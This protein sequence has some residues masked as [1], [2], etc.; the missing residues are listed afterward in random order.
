MPPE[1]DDVRMRELW[2]DFKEGVE[3]QMC[4]CKAEDFY[5][6]YGYEKRGSNSQCTLMTVRPSL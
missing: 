5:C 1:G 2:Q 3:V 4:D 6:E